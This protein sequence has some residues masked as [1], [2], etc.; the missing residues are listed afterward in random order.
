VL[1]PVDQAAVR[2]NYFSRNALIGVFFRRDDAR[3][4]V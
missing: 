4:V 3:A 2:D 1:E